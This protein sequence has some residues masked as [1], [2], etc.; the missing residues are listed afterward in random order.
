MYTTLGKHMDNVS[1]A[2]Y[3]KVEFL[4]MVVQSRSS[5]LIPALNWMMNCTNCSVYVGKQSDHFS[6][7][8]CYR[9]DRLSTSS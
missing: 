4:S 5:D 9:A 7:E 8:L 3:Q 1:T 2:N 6:E